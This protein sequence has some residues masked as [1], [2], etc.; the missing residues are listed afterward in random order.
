MVEYFNEPEDRSGSTITLGH[1]RVTVTTMRNGEPQ[2]KDT[3]KGPRLQMV[4]TD[5]TDRSQ[6][7]L[8]GQ[9]FNDSCKGLIEGLNKALGFTSAQ[10]NSI[11]TSTD[12]ITATSFPINQAQ[13]ICSMWQNAS[14][15]VE[16]QPNPGFDYPKVKW[17][18]KEPKVKRGPE[19]YSAEAVDSGG[20]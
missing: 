11:I 19:H 12:G 20:I 1:H 13:K 4:L 7:T 14:A 5:A 2:L 6:S 10:L 16:I 8:D 17:L 3:E 15:W 9:T 18:P